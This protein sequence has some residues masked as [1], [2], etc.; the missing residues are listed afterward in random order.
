MKEEI[1]L[2]TP[3]FLS[4]VSIE[5]GIVAF[6]VEVEKA[7]AI[8]GKN[9]LIN[10]IGFKPVHTFKKLIYTTKACTPNAINTDNIYLSKGM[11]AL[12]PIVEKVFAIRQNTP[13]G[14]TLITIIVISIIMS[15]P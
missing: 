10:L 7:N 4:K 5:R 14:A 2:E 13:T 11:K 9:F 6:E 12:K 1:L 15:L 8:T 3:I